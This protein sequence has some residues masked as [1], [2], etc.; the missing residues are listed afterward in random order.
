[1]IQTKFSSCPV[2]VDSQTFCLVAIFKDESKQLELELEQKRKSTSLY[3]SK[4][5]QNTSRKKSIKMSK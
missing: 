4:N 3:L 1:M 2:S 5:L